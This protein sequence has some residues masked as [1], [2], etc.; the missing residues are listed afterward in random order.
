MGN[1]CCAGWAPVKLPTWGQI[2]Q[3]RLN[4]RPTKKALGFFKADHEA[5]YKQLPMRPEHTNLAFVAL[6]DPLTSRWVA[7]HQNA[8]LFGATSAVLRYD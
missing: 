8:L 4:V 6:R 2:A 3:M 1:L 5:A 7:F